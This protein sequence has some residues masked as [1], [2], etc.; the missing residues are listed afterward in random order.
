MVG[1]KGADRIG[2]C[3]LPK[4]RSWRFR[5]VATTVLVGFLLGQ[6]ALAFE[7]FGIKFFE[8]DNAET[9]EVIGEPQRYTVDFQVPNGDSDTVDA[10]KDASTLLKD[11]DEPASG[12]SGLIAKAR[13]DYRRL[14]ATLYSQARY[15]GTISILIDG[16]EAADLPPDAELADPASV[17]VTIDP[18]PVFHFGRAEIVNQAPLPTD[19]DDEVD[20]PERKGFASGELAPSGV[21]LL[22]ERLSVEAW[23]QQGH[24]KAEIVERRVEAAHDTDMLDATLV[25]QPGPKASYGTTSVEGTDR[26]DPAFVAYMVDLPVGQEFDPDDISGQT[27]GWRVSTCFARNGSRRAQP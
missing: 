14:L 6:P 18:G 9:P 8:R 1:R 15:G 2:E 20:R 11:S 10:L 24:A 3:L 25:V 4:L 23:R 5:A 27:P 12:A 19:D 26:M 13:G 22:A 7:L 21:V 17:I 16:R